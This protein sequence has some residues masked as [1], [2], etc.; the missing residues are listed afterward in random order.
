MNQGEIK[1]IQQK[2]LN[3]YAT[4]G[5]SFPR[6]E[7]T[8]PYAIHIC[9]TMS[10]QTQLSRVLPYR[11]QRIQEIP[12]YATLATLP[13]KELLQH[14][15]WL[16]FNSRVLRLQECAKIITENFDGEPPKEKEV[17]LK[18]PG[19]WPYTASAICA[20]AWNLPEPVID[21][22]I[23]RILIFLLKLPETISI[24]ELEKEAKKLIP[25]EKSRDRHN[26]LM[27][28]GATILTAKSTKI[29]SIN[30]QSTFEG[31]DRQVRGWIIKNL[32][33][34]TNYLHIKDIQKE[35]P[36]KDIEKIIQQLQKEQIIE[37][38]DWIISL[39]EE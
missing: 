10:Q 30:K 26:A 28:Y 6:R 37:K 9:E 3:R 7:T 12:N 18:L 19:I 33:N 21:T 34:N 5:R 27:D 2:I 20:F 38:K 13:K 31:S 15:S 8:D 39:A 32:A 22:N 1:Q 14:R 17:L 16:G 35:F 11:N 25:P 4:D 36:Q 24:K 29:K 23:R